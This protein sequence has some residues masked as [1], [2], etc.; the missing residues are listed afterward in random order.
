MPPIC[1]SSALFTSSIQIDNFY[2]VSINFW[3]P[4]QT[5]KNRFEMS[6]E[7]FTWNCHIE[8]WFFKNDFVHKPTAFVPTVFRLSIVPPF[9]VIYSAFKKLCPTTSIWSFL[10]VFIIIFGRLDLRARF[11]GK[12]WKSRFFVWKLFWKRPKMTKFWARKQIFERTVQTRIKLPKSCKQKSTI[13][14]T[15]TTIAVS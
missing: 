12:F 3:D 11:I 5:L 9:H 10:D 2:P 14:K 15:G 13:G 1:P 7:I 4:K 8:L 6:L